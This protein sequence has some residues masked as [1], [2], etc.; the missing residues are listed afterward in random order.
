MDTNIASMADRIARLGARLRPHVKTHKATQVMA[1]QLA[2][3][4]AGITVATIHEAEVMADAGANDILLAY[5]PVGDFRL[6]AIERLARRTRLTV[7]C[8]E[9]EH[10]RA[11]SRL[12]SEI[13]YYWE[14][15]V[16][17]GRLG[18]N[19]GRPTAELLESLSDLA[20][21]RLAGIMSFPGHSYAAEGE[22]D[23]RL[24]AA[25]EQA[26]LEATAE[27]L[28]AREIDPGTLSAGAT[29]L[30]RCALARPVEYRFGNY[31]F[32][33]ATQV[34]LGSATVDE[35]AVTVAATVVGRP[36]PDRVILDAGSKALAAERM[37]A[38]TEAFGI[39]RDHP[40]LVVRRLYEEHA[41]CEIADDT[42]L[43]LGDRVEVVPNHACTCVNLH[44]EYT[45]LE[46]NGAVG[47]WQLAARG[48]S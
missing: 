27:A 32:N 19:P 2:A 17:T 31:V 11:L 25:S 3:G 20:G 13:D 1:R 21:V 33:D 4:A 38:A 41:I 30:A 6:K 22:E 14:I 42:E 23:L 12:A 10:V 46:R 16:G 45:V 36:A 40:E 15:E 24:I 29:P 8:S 34:A 37:S 28:L 9:S 35:C 39:V 7:C 18:T 47:T 43:D 44:K 26:A 48:W 5:P